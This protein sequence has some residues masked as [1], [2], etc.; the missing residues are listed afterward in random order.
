MG[1]SERALGSASE[2]PYDGA[3][4]R[5]TEAPGEAPPAPSIYPK[6]GE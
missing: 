3:S 4:E 5:R 2:F 1:A 6:G